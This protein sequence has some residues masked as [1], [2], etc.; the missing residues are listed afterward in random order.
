[1]RNRDAVRGIPLSEQRVTTPGRGPVGAERRICA[2]RDDRPMS[3]RAETCRLCKFCDPG[4]K[5]CH[6]AQ[7]NG[8]GRPARS[9][10]SRR[11]PADS[12]TRRPGPAAGPGPGA[13][14]AAPGHGP[15]GR[16]RGR[17][18]ARIHITT[19]SWSSVITTV[20]TGS[21]LRD[22]A[23]G[24][25]HHRAHRVDRGGRGLVHVQADGEIR[26]PERGLHPGAAQRAERGGAVRVLR[27]QGVELGDLDAGLRQPERAGGLAVQ[28]G[29]DAAQVQPGD[30]DATA[31]G[32]RVEPEPV[33]VG[34]EGAGHVEAVDHFVRTVPAAGGQ[35]LGGGDAGGR[36]GSRPPPC[37][38]T[39]RPGSRPGRATE[40]SRSGRRRGWRGR[41][42]GPRR[43][44]SVRA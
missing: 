25:L 44:R 34:V 26:R 11:A 21:P 3:T 7:L 38:R 30:A 29:G 12:R 20:E 5:P 31:R 35:L 28:A 42:A 36:S 40:A 33:V 19:G 9:L 13:A 18:L 16:R 43:R 6:S 2:V 8:T 32:V 4:R 41:G 24:L 23:D 1:M 39:G 22:R 27:E 37:P 17:A 14:A 10:S 15:R